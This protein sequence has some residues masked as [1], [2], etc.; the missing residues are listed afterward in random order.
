MHDDNDDDIER[1]SI[2]DERE[3]W[4][5]IDWDNPPSD[6]WEDI[7]WDAVWDEYA[8]FEDLESEWLADWS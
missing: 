4:D 2:Q 8:Y 5:G 7:D 1:E 3:F 6:L